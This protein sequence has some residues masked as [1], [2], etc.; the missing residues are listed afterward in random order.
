MHLF[1]PRKA[2]RILPR[3]NILVQ[4]IVDTISKDTSLKEDPKWIESVQDMEEIFKKKDVLQESMNRLIVEMEEIGCEMKSPELGLVDFPALRRGK[5]VYLCWKLGEERVTFWHSLNGGYAER[6]MIDE[7]DFSVEIAPINL[8]GELVR[9]L[10]KL[11]ETYPDYGTKKLSLKIRNANQLS[12]TALLL[13]ASEAG[14][15][16]RMTNKY[17]EEC[18]DVD[19]DSTRRLRG[20]LIDALV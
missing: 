14:T 13:D 3:V 17:L 9:M 12:D 4:E 10:E 8:D 5:P 15:L 1:T 11:I 18:E 6:K 16:V 19:I 20:R 7:S 2:N